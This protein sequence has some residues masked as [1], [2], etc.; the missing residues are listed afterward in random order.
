MND[1]SP[2]ADAESAIDENI[3]KEVPNPIKEWAKKIAEEITEKELRIASA[4]TT[5][6]R[7]EVRTQ[8]VDTFEKSV[9]PFFVL[10]NVK[11]EDVWEEDEIYWLQTSFPAL[12]DDFQDE[13]VKEFDRFVL[14]MTIGIFAHKRRF[15]FPVKETFRA[16]HRIRRT[17]AI[18]AK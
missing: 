18:R 11:V 4:R 3:K 7:N 8:A 9:S 2:F 13:F 15:R 17:L 1:A 16:K 6:L 5:L 10:F 14:L 12:L